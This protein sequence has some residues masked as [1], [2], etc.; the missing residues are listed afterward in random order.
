MY[1]I[2]VGYKGSVTR[3]NAFSSVQSVGI[4]ERTL[5]STNCAFCGS[6][7][8]GLAR[9]Q[10]H[11]FSYKIQIQQFQVQLWWLPSGF[12]QFATCRIFSL[13]QGPTMI[14]CFNLGGH[15]EGFF[16]SFEASSPSKTRCKLQAK[17]LGEIPGS[18]K[19]S[20][21]TYNIIVCWL[22]KLNHGYP[23]SW[24]PKI[25][26]M[27]DWIAFFP[28]DR[29]EKKKC[30]Q[31]PS[32][33]IIVG[34]IYNPIQSLDPGG[35]WILRDEPHGKNGIFSR[36]PLVSSLHHSDSREMCWC[37]ISVAPELL[38]AHC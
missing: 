13:L 30:L 25:N 9:A 23:R 26:K 4:Y 14:A 18:S 35:V 20:R 36:P 6:I 5:G 16:L 3:L 1:C 38:I 21:Y 11:A 28:G 12:R 17:Q 22:P 27:L 34:V 32:V 19:G 15:W 24:L 37:S 2:L 10:L 31:P 33:V 29:G 7:R 8:R